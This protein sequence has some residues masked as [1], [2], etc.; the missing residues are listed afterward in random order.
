MEE[1]TRLEEI[2]LAKDDEQR[3]ITTKWP[4]GS[5]MNWTIVLK[6]IN[7]TRCRI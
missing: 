5:I 2:E 6:S 4:L 1:E 7:L 3:D